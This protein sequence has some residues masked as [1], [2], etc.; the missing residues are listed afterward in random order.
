LK[1]ILKKIITNRVFIFTLIGCLLIIGCLRVIDQLTEDKEVTD[2]QAE[3]GPI[4][5]NSHVPY[6][7]PPFAEPSLERLVAELKV[8]L[9]VQ[10]ADINVEEVAAANTLYTLNYIDSR[11]PPEEVIAAWTERKKL[12][13]ANPEL[14]WTPGFT[15]PPYVLPDP[16]PWKRGYQV[17]TL[18][19]YEFRYGVDFTV[20]DE[21]LE[22][23]YA[24][25]DQ[26]QKGEIPSEEARRKRG[27]ILV[28]RLDLLS[29]AKYFLN[30]GGVGTV[31]LEL[32]REYAERAFSENPDSVEA[33]HIWVLCHDTQEQWEAGF[34][35][36]LD[37][38]PNSALA[39]SGLAGVLC[40][41][42]SR[43]EEGL[44]HIQKAIQLDSRIP[45]YNY[46]LAECYR[47]AGEY[48]KALAVYQGM[49]II[50]SHVLHDYF[51]E[52]QINAYALRMQNENGD[53][54]A[55]E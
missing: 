18:Y 16:P 51:V 46:L 15:L 52:S 21:Q 24:L 3:F 41:R 27:K 29:A 49:S 35:R 55:V 42:L 40:R 20:S 1:T 31:E 10:D 48:E 47:E 44:L 5:G 7:Y 13:I 33:L 8:E 37:E 25:R 28:E 26:A 14:L 53:S 2:T 54:T 11:L 30:N 9:G 50:E 38:F 45:R 12:V 6:T 23:I 34:R 36:M 22:R 32:G 39:H 43:P 17:G 4:A 19:D